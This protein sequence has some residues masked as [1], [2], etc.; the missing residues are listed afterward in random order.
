MLPQIKAGDHVLVWKS[1]LLPE[2]ISGKVIA[3]YDPSKGSIMVHRAID[4][5]DGLYTTKGDNADLPDFFK[6]DKNYIFGKIIYIF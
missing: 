5:R 1:E 2:E 3:F 4:Y 6:P